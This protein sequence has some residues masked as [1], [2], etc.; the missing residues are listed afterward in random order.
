MVNAHSLRVGLLVRVRT[1]L[2]GVLAASLY[3]GGAGAS[4]NLPGWHRLVHQPSL[5]T[6]RTADLMLT[7]GT[8]IAHPT[9]EWLPGNRWFR[10]TPDQFG[11]YV[12]GTWTQIASSTDSRMFMG[13][14]VL[15]DG[16]V[17]VAGGEY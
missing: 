16:R 4:Q 1:S 17:F 2:A 7:D 5:N 3:V 12:N 6:V 11:D 14:T 9:P 15:R 8:V 10:L 13:S